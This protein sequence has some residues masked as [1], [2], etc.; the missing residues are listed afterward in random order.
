[1]VSIAYIFLIFGAI[2]LF[3]GILIIYK[4]D[5]WGLVFAAQGLVFLIVALIINKQNKQIV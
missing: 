3:M 1:M 5:I 2:N 4:G